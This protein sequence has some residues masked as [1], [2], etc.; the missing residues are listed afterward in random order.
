M[1]GV[2]AQEPGAGSWSADSASP[3]PR[4]DTSGSS[5]SLLTRP[6]SLLLCLVPRENGLRGCFSSV[7]NFQRD[8]IQ[9]PRT[10][11]TPR[12]KKSHKRATSILD[13]YMTSLLTSTVSNLTT[14]CSQTIKRDL[15]IP[16]PALIPLRQTF[17]PRS[18]RSS[19]IGVPLS[20]LASHVRTPASI[21]IH[22]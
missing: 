18:S 7:A 22:C 5:A 10:S 4:P 2:D 14:H 11:T 3:A 13:G 19:R 15:A 17:K 21:R 12:L 20:P 16:N 8:K 9:A 6:Q 1:Y